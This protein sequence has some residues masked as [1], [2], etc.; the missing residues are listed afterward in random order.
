MKIDQTSWQPLRS[1]AIKVSGPRDFAG[2]VA[3]RT[4]CMRVDLVANEGTDAMFMVKQYQ[5][6]LLRL[7]ET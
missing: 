4:E 3:Y 2:P 7:P 6:K 5:T 1:D